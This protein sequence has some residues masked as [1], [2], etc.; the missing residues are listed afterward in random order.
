VSATVLDG[1]YEDV[2]VYGRMTPTT[3][4]GATSEENVSSGGTAVMTTVGALTDMYVYSGWAVC[5][6]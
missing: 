3:L 6:S 5:R 2:Y 1:G 4:S